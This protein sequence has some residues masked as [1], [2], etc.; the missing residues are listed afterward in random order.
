MRTFKDECFSVA[1][2]HGRMLQPRFRVHGGR[3]PIHIQRSD[4]YEPS[5]FLQRVEPPTLASAVAVPASLAMQKEPK[6]LVKFSLNSTAGCPDIKEWITY[7][8]SHLPSHVEKS[9]ITV[10]GVWRSGSTM[11][12]LALPVAV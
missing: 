5:T 4:I 8:T 9:A 7:L 11:V 3:T 2:L 12:L 1:M 6:V 10:E